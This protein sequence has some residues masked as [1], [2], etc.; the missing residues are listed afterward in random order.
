MLTKVPGRR[1]GS[2]AGAVPKHPTL[3]DVADEV[4]LG[5]ATVSYALRGERGSAETMS[6]VR[7]AA[8]RLGYHANPMAAALAGGRSPLVAVLVGTMR[9]LWQQSL[10]A[11]LSRALLAVG[12]QAIVA[13]ADGD[14]EQE[15]SLLAELLTL[16]PAGLLVAPLDPAAEMWGRVAS[17]LPV[18]A[19]GDQLSSAPEAGAVTFGNPAGF[20]AVF[21]HLTGLGHR[22]IAVVLPERTSTPDRPAERLVA[23]ATSG[24]VEVTLVPTKPATSDPEE[25]TRHLAAAISGPARPTAVFCLTD[26]FAFAALRAARTLGVSVPEDL[27]V[28]GFENLEVTDLIGLTTVD[29]GGAAVVQ[30]AVEQLVAAIDATTPLHTRVCRPELIIRSSTGPVPA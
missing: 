3:Q 18:L 22:R 1:V 15:Q 11:D 25:M 13:D 20:R 17:N 2:Y 19:L 26:S 5:L 8:D 27:S 24:G 7:D 30:A 28:V 10:V 9:D 6:R 23:E 4:G 29:W 16:R 12:R 21:D 14:A